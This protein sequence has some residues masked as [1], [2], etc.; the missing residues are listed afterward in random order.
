TIS[1]E[2]RTTT[3]CS[4][5]FPSIVIVPNVVLSIVIVTSSSESH[6]NTQAL[7]RLGAGIIL[8]QVPSVPPIPIGTRRRPNCP[9]APRTSRE[10]GGANAAAAVPGEAPS[11]DVVPISADDQL[12]AAWARYYIH[13][14]K[15][16]VGEAF[17]ALA[18]ANDEQQS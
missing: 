10:S 17:I 16:M 5:A 2:R 12:A 18:V 11:G 8:V 15:M 3:S 14:T 4:Y 6:S 13:D 9:V 7:R 1:P